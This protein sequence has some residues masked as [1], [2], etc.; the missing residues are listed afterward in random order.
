MTGNELNKNIREVLGKAVNSLMVNDYDEAVKSLKAA[1]V[2]DPQNPEIL[3]NLSVSYARMGLHKSAVDYCLR[4][5]SLSQQTV[6]FLLVKKMLAFSLISLERTADAK[7]ALNEVL[8]LNDRDAAALAMLGFCHEKTGNMK[9]A[10]ALHKKILSIEPGNSN[11]LNSAAYLTAVTGGPLQEALRMVSAAL[12]SHPESPAY[13]DTLGFILMR[14]GDYKRSDAAFRKA[15]TKL[16]GNREIL[17]HIAE[18]K[19]LISGK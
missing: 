3:F 15:L 5:L 2:L 19:Q 14:S 10:L 7:K 16:P 8:D 17:A 12:K 18:L 9:E 11:G 1:E 13:L 6:D 4:I